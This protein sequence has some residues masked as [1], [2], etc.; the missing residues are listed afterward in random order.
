MGRATRVRLKVKDQGDLAIDRSV[1]SNAK[2]SRGSRR[3][4]KRRK[5]S[6]RA[7]IDKNKKK[8]LKTMSKGTV[9]TTEVSERKRSKTGKGVKAPANYALINGEN[10]NE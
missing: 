7:D 2:S 8:V 9:D 3:G 1:R 4:S 5:K 10:R 6:R